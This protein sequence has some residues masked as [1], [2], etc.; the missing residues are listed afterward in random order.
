MRRCYHL[1]R[2]T[3]IKASD[4]VGILS[5]GGLKHLIIQFAAKMRCRIV[6]LSGFDN[7][8]AEAVR[9]GAH[10][11]IAIKGVKALTVSSSLNR[12]LII[13]AMSLSWDLI[14]P[15]MTPRSAIYS[16]SM[17]SEK[18]KIPYMALI[19]QGISV[20]G[21]HVASRNQH[22]QM[23]KFATL[24]QI[25]PIVETF[26]MT[27]EGIKDAIDKLERGEVYYRAVLIPA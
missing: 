23:L 16:L 9:L 15:I 25:K 26:L 5:V 22:R 17:S 1:Q 3:D 12:L 8:K 7:K 18:L 10:D 21:S 27:E 2:P 13:A 6:V 11:F 4:T 19:L 24:H 14:L 20:Q